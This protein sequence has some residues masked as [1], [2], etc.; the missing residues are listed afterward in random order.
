VLG[1]SGV[2]AFEEQVC[3]EVIG[4]EV[5]IFL[6]C[7]FDGVDVDLA[8]R[9]VLVIIQLVN[10]AVCELALDFF[11]CERVVAMFVEGVLN[12]LLCLL[13]APERWI[14]GKGLDVDWWGFAPA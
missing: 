10:T 3:W 14:G 7:R 4:V 6:A 2:D 13:G 8:V 5:G 11:V 1:L 9:G 12:E